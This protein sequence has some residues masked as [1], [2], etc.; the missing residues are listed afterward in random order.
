MGGR[1]D[2]GGGVAG[3]WGVKGEVRA[4]GVGEAGGRGRGCGG[5]GRGV[6]VWV[7]G[8]GGDAEGLLG[9]EEG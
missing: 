1:D 8:G 7:G 9:G 6:E 4:E 2:A 3:G 5:G